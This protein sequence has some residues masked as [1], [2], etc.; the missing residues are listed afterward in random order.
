[1]GLVLKNS[2]LRKGTGWVEKDTMEF[3]YTEACP[4]CSEKIKLKPS[5]F[6]LNG[7]TVKCANCGEISS[8]E[9][10]D[11]LYPIYMTI[12]IWVTVLT[13]G[14]LYVVLIVLMSICLF[15][16]MH[17]QKLV[18]LKKINPKSLKF[19]IPNFSRMFKQMLIPMISVFI[20][21]IIDICRKIN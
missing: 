2:W 6:R 18:K 3:S 4:Y 8:Y 14:T 21:L 5:Y 16:H 13:S 17:F 10:S 20:L 7:H 11:K 1:M 9:F 19:W 15:V 12:S